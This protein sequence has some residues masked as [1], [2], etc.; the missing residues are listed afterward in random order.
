MAPA[1]SP[2]R[3]GTIG[4]TGRCSPAITRREAIPHLGEQQVGRLHQPTAD[5]DERGIE[6]VHQVRQPE[7]DPPGELVEHRLGLRIAVARRRGD[8]LASDGLVVAAREGD[9][10]VEAPPAGGVAR[11]A[12]QPGAGGEPLPAPPLA[13]GTGGSVGVD[14]HV[15]GLPCEAVGPSQQPAAGDDAGADAGAEGDHERPR[16]NPAAAPAA[17]SATAWQLASLSTT[18]RDTGALLEQPGQRHVVDAPEVRAHV[19]RARAVH[20]AGDAARRRYRGSAPASATSS[21]S[22]STK[23]SPPSGV[24]T[25]P[26]ATMVPGT[27][28]STAT[29]STLV[30][31]TSSPMEMVTAESMP[32]CGASSAGARRSARARRDRR[33]RRRS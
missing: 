14:D 1:R 16:P 30:P 22:V 7:R 18:S 28:G 33:C 12:A 25:R 5:H 4:T 27:L 24:G 10:G 31:P 2:S 29:P 21:S 26:S 17:C 20:Q 11:Q 9:G 15:P 32:R 23:P 13:A 6:D 8:V 19:E 3:A